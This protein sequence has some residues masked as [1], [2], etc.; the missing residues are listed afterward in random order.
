M[1]APSVLGRVESAG[2]GGA[3]IADLA[4]WMLAAVSVGTAAAAAAAAAKKKLTRYFV[5]IACWHAD[6]LSLAGDK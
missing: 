5:S 1:V 2:I 6:K 3:T 4:A